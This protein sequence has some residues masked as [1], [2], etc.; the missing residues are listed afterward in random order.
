MRTA[1]ASTGKLAEHEHGAPVMRGNASTRNTGDGEPFFQQGAQGGK[2]I[3]G[4][5]WLR[6]RAFVKHDPEGG[7]RGE[8]HGLF[9]IRPPPLSAHRLP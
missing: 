1:G 7:L 3:A 6:V 8:S 4:F 9:Q 5:E 2:S